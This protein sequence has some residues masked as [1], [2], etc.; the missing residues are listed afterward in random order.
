MNESPFAKAD[1]LF[2]AALEVPENR[3]DDFLQQACGDDESLL[4]RLQAMLEQDAQARENQSVDPLAAV[5]HSEQRQFKS[6][7]QAVPEQIGPFRLL[8][9]LGQGGMGAIYLGQ[10]IDSDFE[11]RVAIKLLRDLDS[12][13][14]WKYYII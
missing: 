14:N 6:E 1:R 10:R 11:Q 7:H 4:F 3:R 5:V 2:H 13:G 12:S 9:K 8:R